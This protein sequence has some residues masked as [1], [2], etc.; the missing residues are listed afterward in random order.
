MAS[1]G[2]LK[3]LTKAITVYCSNAPT[4]PLPEELIQTIEAYISR[5]EKF[6]E[7]GSEKLHDE[8]QSIYQ[9]HVNGIH[10]NLAGFI[11]VLRRL[12][13]ILRVPSRVF[14]WWDTLQEVTQANCTMEKSVLDEIITGM[15]D[16]LLVEDQY[17]RESDSN[18]TLNT[19]AER[20]YTT[21]L[22]MHHAVETG[23]VQSAV[24]SERAIRGALVTWGKKKPKP[25]LDLLDR[26]FV[27]SEYRTRTI[28]MLSEFM[29]NQPPHLYLM[30]QTPLFGN[31]LRCLQLDTS[32]VV[33]SLALTTLIMALPHMPSALIPYLPTLFNIY[34]RLLFWD[35]ERTGIVEA[36]ADD[37]ENKGSA[38]NTGWET[39]TFSPDTDELS[40]VH[41]AD[42][43]TI[44]YGLYPLNFTDYIRKPHR[45]LR[46]ANVANEADVDVQPT[47]MRHKSEK[48]RRDHL[49][50]PN[51][52]T[53]TVESEKTDMGRWLNSEPAVLVADCFALRV[54]TRLGAEE[55][56]L[57]PQ[58]Q[59]GT[60]LVLSMDGSGS[61]QEG[62]QT[63]LLSGL[64]PDPGLESWRNSRGSGADSP[65]SSRVPSLVQ[66][67]ASLSSRP[68]NA[69][70]SEAR[71][72]QAGPGGDSPT[73][74]PQLTVSNPQTQLQDML[75]SNKAIKSGLHQSLANDSVPSLA[76]SHAESA[77]ERP[78]SRVPTP[79]PA[80][81]ST[82]SLSQ[83]DLLS[84]VT[85]L[86]Q[87]V[88]LLQ[89]DL[90]FERYLKQQHMA[91]IGE[92]RRA[93]V[94]EA[95]SEAE[96]QNLIMANRNLKN[97]LEDAKKAEMQIRKESEKSRALA[98]KWESDFSAKLLARRE[99]VKKTKAEGEALQQEL[100]SAKQECEKLRKIVCEAEVRELNS[101][102]NKQSVELDKKDMV[103]LK[104]EVERL[105]MFERDLQTKEAERETAMRLAAEA[106]KR[107]EELN[108]KL[109]AREHELQ[110]TTRFFQS[111]IATLHAKL[112]EAQAG[113]RCR[114]ANESNSA[115]QSALA[116]SRAKQTEMERE[117]GNLLRRYTAL[118]LQYE[119]CKMELNSTMG[120]SR[121]ELGFRMDSENGSSHSTSPVNVRAGPHRILTDHDSQDP[122]SYTRTAP[123]DLKPSTPGAVSTSPGTPAELLGF[124]VSAS[125]ELRFHGRGGVQNKIRRE[126]KGKQKDEGGD[127]KEKKSTGLRGIRG[128]V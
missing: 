42:Y 85:Q 26:F 25:F 78:I 72:R 35:H 46:H 128:F 101:R 122:A 96:T 111:Q 67:H 45:Y 55:H 68:S 41:L 43:F 29:Q 121:N 109:A 84:R 90:N 99:E 76:L 59:G 62:V 113:P 24:A 22:G 3:D 105:T 30:L 81:P 38:S 61:E 10:A 118:Q 1:S 16:M 110:K 9:K 52:Y 66:R 80:A 92:L 106:E 36:G 57:A 2:S 13:P 83:G 119:E 60:S 51:F 95:A 91:H 5:H 77:H 94:R 34:A 124:G 48:F 23:D 19:F 4:L 44:L 40:I 97:R 74:P 88:M 39:C 73:L 98:K 50:H 6:D 89:N 86:Q 47:E 31:L 53:L 11:A 104:A 63:A 65:A 112:T 14:Y 18:T 79:G 115:I 12:M 82:V 54:P 69:D 108:M 15:L 120:P 127:K 64:G 20:L 33:V 93:H 125:P 28:R 37:S 116:A 117:Y 27:K 87:H 123:T 8:L 70:M 58:L 49:L 100:Q 7:S 102:Q 17:D 32:T 103:R 56:G 126:D 107:T 71:S 75:Q 114:P 21:W